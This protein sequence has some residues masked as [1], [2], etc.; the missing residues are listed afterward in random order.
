[1]ITAWIVALLL[2]GTDVEPPELGALEPLEDALWRGELRI[3]LEGPQYTQYLANQLS[4]EGKPIGFI[5]EKG[6]FEVAYT[7]VIRF[8]INALGEHNMA[9]GHRVEASYQVDREKRSSYRKEIFLEKQRTSYVENVQISETE[10]SRVGFDE[11]ASFDSGD[12]AFGSL[13]FLPSGRMDRRGQIQV[14]GDMTV[15]ITGTGKRIFTYE[16]QPESEEEPSTRQV[17]ELD[18]TVLLPFTFDF[19]IEHRKDPVAGTFSVE[20]D[21]R[22]PF[23]S[24]DD[25]D[26]AKRT[27]RSL[28]EGSGTFRITPLFG[29][30]KKK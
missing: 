2:L 20:V 14:I 17:A 10:L 28:I 21:V 9:A 5:K 16:R 19:S 26:A 4:E 11:H 29:K 8:T 22:S 23:P 7:L 27:F 25:D 15:P 1:M 30:K 13:R 3:S 6:D 24:D 12:F 18:K